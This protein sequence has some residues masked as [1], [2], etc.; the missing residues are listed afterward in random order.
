MRSIPPPLTNWLVI[1]E[2]W[3]CTPKWIT[4][5]TSPQPPLYTDTNM[6]GTLNTLCVASSSA[7]VNKPDLGVGGEEGV[8]VRVQMWSSGR[9]IKTCTFDTC[10]L[11]EDFCTVSSAFGM[12]TPLFPYTE[13]RG[14]ITDAH[15]QHIKCD[16]L[17][18]KV[19]KKYEEGRS[20][21]LDWPLWSLWILGEFF[22]CIIQTVSVG[23]E[24]QIAISVNHTR[25]IRSVTNKRETNQ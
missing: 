3:F 22:N 25:I 4:L 9:L 18:W 16:K 20:G 24:K 8:W 5:P 11:C 17:Q 2:L 13:R 6:C 23:G 14:E 12:Q 19:M 10:Q 15:T 7:E 1:A 21:W